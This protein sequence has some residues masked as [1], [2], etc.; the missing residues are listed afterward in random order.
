MWSYL[1][2]VEQL[3]K[4]EKADMSYEERYLYD[5]LVKGGT[6]MGVK[7]FPIK[8]ALELQDAHDETTLDGKFEVFSK[9]V[10][11]LQTQLAE[12]H[13]YVH[14]NF[15]EQGMFR[16]RQ[17]RMQDLAD[18]N[19]RGGGLM[20]PRQSSF[21][22]AAVSVRRAS[23]A[24]AGLSSAPLPPIGSLG[25]NSGG[26]LFFS[27]APQESEET[28]F[29]FPEEPAAYPQASSPE[30]T[31]GYL[32]LLPDAPAM[33][34]AVSTAASQLISRR[35]ELDARRAELEIRRRRGDNNRF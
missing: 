7:V 34:V 2:F 23:A 24:M 10:L 6:N 19:A 26:G 11:T 21:K 32:D 28:S 5:H 14:E 31:N 33:S 1:Y 29:G 15:E 22:K 4:I 25:M 35:E 8:Q 9:V 16:K 30:D 12:L 13:S 27:G 18:K 3:K 20:S 17:S